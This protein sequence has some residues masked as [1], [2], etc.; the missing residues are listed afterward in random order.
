MNFF[1]FFRNT[2]S[3]YH[4]TTMNAYKA[5]EDETK[6]ERTIINTNS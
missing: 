5:V 4:E 2:I 1:V 6:F 3:S